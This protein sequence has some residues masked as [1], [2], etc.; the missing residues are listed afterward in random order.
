MT[1]FDITKLR[2]GDKVRLTYVGTYVGNGGTSRVEHPIP[3]YS[4]YLKGAESVEVLRPAWETAVGTVIRFNNNPASTWVL[5]LGKWRHMGAGAYSAF[6]TI[7]EV[8]ADYSCEPTV[9]YDA[10]K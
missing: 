3:A 9:L 10:S 6:D 5:A 7:N 8:R 1:D 2:V 4:R